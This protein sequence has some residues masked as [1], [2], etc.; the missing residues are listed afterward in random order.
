M[1][2]CSHC[3]GGLDFL[4]GEREREGFSSK[5]QWQNRFSHDVWGEEL[6]QTLTLIWMWCS[7]ML[8]RPVESPTSQHLF[9]TEWLRGRGWAHTVPLP[10]HSGMSLRRVGYRERWGW[11]L[12]DNGLFSFTH[13]LA[14][15]NF[16]SSYILWWY[17]VKASKLAQMSSWFRT[18]SMSLW[19]SPWSPP[20]LFNYT[21]IVG[22]THEMHWVITI[23]A[24]HPS[25]C[26]D[27]LTAVQ[28]YITGC[29]PNGTLFTI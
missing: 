4:L 16:C 17:S 11:R 22:E 9:N 1:K 7:W 23:N 19:F 21:E 29:V 18:N 12:K 15:Y 26:L 5:A 25:Q 13:P 3:C 27:N 10:S 28:P 24:R 6:P 2:V 8:T 14:Y 20:C